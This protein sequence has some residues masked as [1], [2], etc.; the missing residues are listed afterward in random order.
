MFKRYP[1]RKMRQSL[2]MIQALV[3]LLLATEGVAWKQ[4]DYAMMFILNQFIKQFDNPTYTQYVGALGAYLR[5][6]KRLIDEIPDGILKT[7]SAAE[8]AKV[9]ADYPDLLETEVQ[10]SKQ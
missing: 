1:F 9:S 3:A 6:G 7:T 10:P 4:Q 2:H 8:W 5:F